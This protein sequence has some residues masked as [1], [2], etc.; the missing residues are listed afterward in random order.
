MSSLFHTA[1]APVQSPL[2]P[3]PPEGNGMGEGDGRTTITG[4]MT[5]FFVFEILKLLY[6]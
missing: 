3:V 5:F 4:S 6:Y 1:V 2:P